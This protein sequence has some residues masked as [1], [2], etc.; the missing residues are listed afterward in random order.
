MTIMFDENFSFLSPTSN[1]SSGSYGDC[2][3]SDVS[4]FTSR[5][6]SPR[7]YLRRC[8]IS[9][10][11]P[12]ALPYR[13]SRFNSVTSIPSN[14]SI[15]ALTARLET[16]AL[17]SASAHLPASPTPTTPSYSDFSDEGFVDG[18]T[19]LDADLKH[20]STLWDLSTPDLN[21]TS[22]PRN[23]NGANNPPS[24]SLRRRQ[25]QALVR[26]QCLV[27]RAPDLMMVAEECHP[28]SLPLPE[29][30][31]WG[32][33]TKRHSVSMSGLSAGGRPGARVEK[34]RSPSAAVKRTP[35]M[36]KRNT[37]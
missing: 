7:P 36:R 6:S 5:S 14:A 18:P 13:D 24:F 10:R 15:T 37:R 20:D 1:T 30:P 2:T 33:G 28:S 32:S 12:P 29:E 22:T 8:S 16:H 11:S 23:S 27:Q 34:E 26:L 25:R 35:R 19:P 21:I 9:T 31:V 4:P 17:S 3:S